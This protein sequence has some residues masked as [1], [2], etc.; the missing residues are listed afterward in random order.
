MK[1]LAKY[2]SSTS[3]QVWMTFS[4]RDMNTDEKTG[5]RT[6]E[7]VKLRHNGVNR[8]AYIL[9]PGLGEVKI[10]LHRPVDWTADRSGTVKRTPSGVWYA[11][12]SVEQELKTVL[13]GNSK[14][15]GMVRN[16]RLAKAILGAGWGDLIRY[17][18]YKSVMLRG[19]VRV[20]RCFVFLP[21]KILHRKSLHYLF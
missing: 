5:T 4:A 19:R 10:K 21:L 9:L 1:K 2:N 14:S 13:T 8:F 20:V 18:T 15:T 7:T 17:T 11:N 3:P 12:I 6:T 16:P